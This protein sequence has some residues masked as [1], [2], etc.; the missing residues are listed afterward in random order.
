MPKTDS[1]AANLVFFVWAICALAAPAPAVAQ[2]GP[3]S[4][5]RPAPN[6]GDELIP[7]DIPEIPPGEAVSLS[8]AISSADE[9]N[10]SLEATRMELERAEGELYGA[11]ATL[12]PTADASLTY[13][14]RD[15][16]DSMNF[17]GMEITTGR[18]NNLV[19]GVDVSVPI[20]SPSAWA[21]I[22]VGRR[23]KELAALTVES[24]RQSLLLTVAQSYYQALA[25]RALIDVELEQLRAASRHLEI[26]KARLA[27]GV[28]KRLDVIRARQDVVNLYDALVSAHAS[29]TNTR[30]TLGRL[31]GLGGL[32]MPSEARE[33]AVPNGEDE[34]LVE[35]G[36]EQRDDLKLKRSATELAASRKRLTWMQFVPSLA[37]SW[38]LTH[39]FTEGSGTSDSDA[40]R[41]TA[42]LVLSVPIYTQTRYADL[43]VSRAAV[44]QS[45]L[46]TKDAEVAAEVE[47]RTARRNYL[48]AVRKIAT[49]SEQASLA[50][51]S[52]VLVETSYRVGTGSSLDVTDARRTS[53][54]A[55][56][57]LATRRLEAQIALLQLMRSVGEDLHDLT[58]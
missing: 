14:R 42:Y 50:A 41:W 30:D 44:R 39:Q 53:A 1:T 3:P 58:D 26:A 36:L 8:G 51:E 32:P 45:E 6:P 15:H 27:S 52:L 21:G 19:G 16:E 7:F 24:A 20:V 13:T 4:P 48:T 56:I 11:W 37:A 55:E 17:G 9:R 5:Q 47:I 2:E 22:G 57:N 10:L 38:S 31:T 43:D 54:E 33:M 46:E 25:A 23:G 40:T 35:R 28:G 29:L 34:E 18:V 12:F 49:A